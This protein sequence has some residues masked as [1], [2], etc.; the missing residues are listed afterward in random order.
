MLVSFN[1][2]KVIKDKGLLWK[3]ARRDIN[4]SEIAFKT[5]KL[6]KSE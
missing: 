4:G 3:D 5:R 2:T 6:L 1:M